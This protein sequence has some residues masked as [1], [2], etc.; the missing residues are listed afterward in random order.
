MKKVKH[1]LK[2]RTGKIAAYTAVAS[3]A[4]VSASAHAA[5]TMPAP[6]T[7]FFADALD[8]WSQLEALIWPIL[9]AV[10]IAMFVMR[11]TKQGANKA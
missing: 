11:K 9:G 6:V 5:Y 7:A 4:V 2:Q 3:T 8:A 1:W 10:L